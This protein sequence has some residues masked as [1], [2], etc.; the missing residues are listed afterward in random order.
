MLAAL[1]DAGFID[2]GRTVQRVVIDIQGGHSP[3]VYVQYEGDPD[4]LTGVVDQVAQSM[5]IVET[6]MGRTTPDGPMQPFTE[7][8]YW[9]TSADT[10]LNSLQ[11]A[12][13]DFV[14]DLAQIKRPGYLPDLLAETEDVENAYIPVVFHREGSLDYAKRVAYFGPM[15]SEMVTKAAEVSGWQ[16][17]SVDNRLVPGA[18]YAIDHIPI[19]DRCCADHA[20]TCDPDPDEKLCCP[21][22][23]EVA[24]G[25]H[26]TPTDCVLAPCTVCPTGD[27]HHAAT[28]PGPARDPR[29]GTRAPLQVPW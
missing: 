3:L 27:Q 24:H 26:P 1:I 16:Q 23:S 29:P 14:S 4:R 9:P 12:H 22:C 13:H 7:S 6:S 10:V 21:N 18:G 2:D 15:V 5:P 8:R 19:A 20:V 17:S 11:Q 25:L 28:M